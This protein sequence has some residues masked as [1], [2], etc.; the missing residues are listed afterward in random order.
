[1]PPTA[2]TVVNV[3]TG[4]PQT[5]ARRRSAWGW[6][7]QTSMIIMMLMA[8]LMG[9]QSL[10]STGEGQ[11][12]VVR[13][14]L[15]EIIFEIIRIAHMSHWQDRPL[16]DVVST[17]GLD[18]AVIMID[19]VI[20]NWETAKLALDEGYEFYL[21]NNR[22]TNQ[23]LA[24][25]TT[26]LMVHGKII[27]RDLD[28]QQFTVRHVYVSPIRVRHNPDQPGYIDTVIDIDPSQVIAYEN[29]PSD[30]AQAIEIGRHARVHQA[31]KQT[32]LAFSPEALHASHPYSHRLTVQKGFFKGYHKKHVYFA[33]HRYGEWIDAFREGQITR[34]NYIGADI[35]FGLDGVPI[36]RPG[37]HVTLVPYSSPGKG[38]N[39]RMVFIRPADDESIEGTITKI[40]GNRLSLEVTTCPTGQADDLRTT[41]V[42]VTLENDAV[43]NLDG[44]KNQGREKA[45]HIGHYVR[46]LPRWSG[47]ILV[48]D[49]DAEKATLA[50]QPPAKPY[51]IV[52]EKMHGPF[53]HARH[54]VAEENS[55]VHFQTYAT[56]LDNVTYQWY[57][58][59]IRIPGARQRHYEHTA[60]MDD[61]ESMFTCVAQSPDGDTSAPPIKLIVQPDT[62][63]L[64]IANAVIAD[65]ETIQL[66]F[67]KH[68]TK[69]SAEKIENYTISDGVSI[70]RATLIGDR[71]TVILKTSPLR[72]QNSYTLTLNNISD[73]S[74]TANIIASNTE[75]TV[76]LQTMFRYLRFV[77]VEQMDGNDPRIQWIRFFAENT[78]YGE[79]KEYFG[80]GVSKKEAAAVFHPDGRL[81]L[82]SG[83]AVG[84][85]LG[86]GNHISPDAVFIETKTRGGGRDVKS[87][88]IEGSNDFEQW[89]TIHDGS[90]HT[91]RAGETYHIDLD[92]SHLDPGKVLATKKLQTI[93]FPTIPAQRLSN[94]LRLPD[95]ASSDLPLTL[96]VLDGPAQIQDGTMTFSGTG[97]VIVHAE[98]VGNNEFY[99][100]YSVT[101]SFEVTAD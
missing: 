28:K 18:Q 59:G 80:V 81:H 6:F 46:V 70:E 14:N 43:Y 5:P 97:T 7:L 60:L 13:F 85:D 51:F 90:N 20:S 96:T 9:Q 82:K 84:V 27:A 74:G 61:H 39:S 78:A 3:P 42:E 63:P 40:D 91:L 47:A 56:A 49:V 86:P 57:Q 25:Q 53:L 32:I 68:I 24:I 22:G 98:Q 69:K 26:P 48:R 94:E 29:T 31:R 75:V 87:W 100:A 92:L 23:V 15:G 34:R 1:M 44:K 16:G 41:T 12:K 58:D 10:A 19:G 54:E 11:G 37:D 71:T 88:A 67:N 79:A 76:R 66:T 8:S 64:T 50:Q 73:R 95:R 101:R 30:A 65:S 2:A 35:L 52:G 55:T 72:A 89:F 77:I 83:Q 45:L 17:G 99:P 93:D 4:C 33:E 36:V 21:H 38:L 62:S